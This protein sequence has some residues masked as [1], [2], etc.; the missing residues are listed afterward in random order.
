MREPVPR[1]A[2]T[3]LVLA[4]GQ[5]QRMGGVDKG[6]AELAGRPMIEYVLAGLEPQVGHVLISA[7]RNLERYAGFGHRVV[8]DAPGGFLGPLAGMLGA[9]EGMET[10]LLLT[11]PCDSP[12]VAPDLATCM[13]E[14]LS[15]AGADLAVAHDGVRPQPVFLML[16][17]RLAADLGDYL[18]AGGRRI[19]R[20]FSR[21][22]VAEADLSHRPESF[23]NV[24]DPDERLRVEAM[25]LSRSVG[26]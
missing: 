12:L 11:A 21:H 26:P 17:R 24:N 7:N 2:I 19:D 14:A 13:F 4:G 8:T 5:A 23:V 16:R 10:D 15:G 6:L 3:G 9:L 1:D 22:L 18:A 20:W 25:L